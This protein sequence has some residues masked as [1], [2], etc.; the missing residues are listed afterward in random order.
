[1]MI[2]GETQNKKGKIKRG[3]L[4]F[5]YFGPPCLIPAQHSPFYDCRADL[6]NTRCRTGTDSAKFDFE[7][8]SVNNFGH[9]I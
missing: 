5:S 1:M 2:R 8:S 9:Y 3:C 6:G 7:R 4:Q